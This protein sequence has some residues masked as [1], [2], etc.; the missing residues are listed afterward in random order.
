MAGITR[1]GFLWAVGASA[2][3]VPMMARQGLAS[4]KS[5]K[6]WAKGVGSCEASGD[7]PNVILILCDDLGWGDLGEFWQNRRAKDMPKIATPHLDAA[8]KQGVMLTHAYTTAPVCAPARASM[9][10]GKHQGH[11]NLR[12]NMFDRPID[13]HMTLGTVMQTA[14]YDTWHLG[15]WGIGGGYESNG[16]PRRAMA[17]DAG[18]DYSYGYP[19][20]SHGHAY[21]HFNGDIDDKGGSPL[22]E[23]VSAAAH[24]TRRYAK[25][26]EGVSDFEQD[27]QGTYYRRLVSNQEGQYCY[28]TDLFTAK[29]KQLI[30][31]Q[32]AVAPKRPFFAYACFTTIHGTGNAGGGRG[33]AFDKS[34][35]VGMNLHVPPAAYPA[36]DDADKEWGGGV[37]FAK[38]Q[39]KLAFKGTPETANTYIH[40]DCKGFNTWGRRRYATAVRRLDD[41]IGDLLHFLQVRGLEKKTLVIFTSD[42]GPAGE[43]L[44]AGGLAWVDSEKDGFDSNGPLKGMKRWSYEGGVREPTF[45]LWPGT[46]PASGAKSPRICETPFQ[47]PAWMATLADVA[48]LPQPAHCDGVSL[49]PTLTQCGKQLPSRIYTE[50]VDGGSGY[51]FGFEQMVR[52]GEYVLIRNHGKQSTELYNVVEDVGQAKNLADDPKHAARLQGMTNLLY[53]C[54][55]PHTQLGTPGFANGGGARNKVDATALPAFPATVKPD[56][57]WQVRLYKDAAGRVWPWVPNFATLRADKTLTVQPTA[58]QGGFK[59]LHAKLPKTGAYGVA[60]R[61]WFDVKQEGPVTFKAL[62][63]G[64]CQLWIHEAHALEWEAGDCTDGKQVTLP[65]A[66][67]RHPF[68]LY[69]TTRTGRDG[70]CTVAGLE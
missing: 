34:I 22:V 41:A 29:L 26:S 12:D 45:A 61:G 46:I 2:V 4:V 10:T 39:G 49:L 33:T 48:G 35:K 40:P 50:Y 56:D 5:P 17:C 1:R 19:A 9:V 51:G 6:G 65:M 31:N 14:G 52:D 57:V 54:R 60:I 8:M 25:L 30:R 7:R 36:T 28:D 44:S 27:P 62:G 68:R 47:F 37:T 32:Q 70:L 20:H 38:E 55:M 3:T 63:A 24:Q 21:Y 53:T 58:T 66:Q 11:C 15:K 67:G 43:A 13:A 23:N 64:G 59:Q 69:L 42:N 16:Q 18:F